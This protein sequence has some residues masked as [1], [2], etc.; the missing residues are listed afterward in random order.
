[1]LSHI[2]CFLSILGR[3][4]SLLDLCWMDWRNEKIA[5]FFK[6]RQGY[7]PAVKTKQRLTST[8]LGVPVQGFSLSLCYFQ[9]SSQL[10]ASLAFLPVP[11]YLLLGSFLWGVSWRV[12]SAKICRSNKQKPENLF[13]C[14]V[15]FVWWY[16]RFWT[17]IGGL[18]VSYIESDI[19]DMLAEDLQYMCRFLFLDA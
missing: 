3:V 1:M 2:F 14:V 5:G 4:P 17:N 10:Q 6:I 9:H 18:Y 8:L 15:Q 19:T 7:Y 11:K 13:Y 16:N 12:S